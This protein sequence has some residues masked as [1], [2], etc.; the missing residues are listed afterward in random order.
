MN[1]V[2]TY[3]Q[4]STLIFTPMHTHTNTH[5]HS[6]IGCEITD[7]EAEKI[8]SAND[9]IELLKTKLDVH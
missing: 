2:R 9:A 4:F 5:T 7:E 3:T 8:F 6:L 1:L